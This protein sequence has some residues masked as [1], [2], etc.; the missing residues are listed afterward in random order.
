MRQIDPLVKERLEQEARYGKDWAK[1][2]VCVPT[3][4]LVMM[5]LRFHIQNGIL[6]WLIEISKGKE[7]TLREIAMSVLFINFAAIHTTTTVRK[8]IFGDKDF[9]HSLRLLHIRY[10]TWQLVQNMCILCVKKL[11]Q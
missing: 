9:A 3:H 6:S 11:K 10:S 7:H 2:Q 4:F 8:T 5:L 1:V